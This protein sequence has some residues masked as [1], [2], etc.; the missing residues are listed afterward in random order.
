MTTSYQIQYDYNLSHHNSMALSCHADAVVMLDNEAQ[1]DALTTDLQRAEPQ[2]QYSSNSEPKNLT[3]LPWLIISGGSNVLLPSKLH[4]L[5]LLPRMRGIHILHDSS[6]HIDI[7]VMAGENWHQL[8]TYCCQQGWYGIEN[9]ALIP[10][11]V[12]AAPVQNIGAYG[13]QLEDTLIHVRAYHLPT[14]QWHTLGHADCQFGYR[15]SIFKQSPNNWLI[16]RVAFRLHKNPERIEACYGDVASHAQCIA[17]QHGRSQATARDVMYA[18][19]DIRQQKLPDPKRLPNCG[20]FFQN[21]IVTTQHFENLQQQYP[22]IVGYPLANGQI[23]VAAGWLIEQAGLKGKGIDPILTHTQ[24]ALVLTNH[25]PHRATQADICCTQD[26]IC[27]RI[28]SL[29]AIDLQ[30]EP[31]MLDASGHVQPQ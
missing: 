29:F 14:Q 1:I 8:V 15:D 4:A 30:R 12:G 16:S 13:V 7:E 31:V 28:Q 3:A 21:P 9:L 11:L 26:F 5:V 27:Q 23:K 24:Q 19:I 25:A 22:S 20:S 2:P 17:Q 18:I 6:D 10:G